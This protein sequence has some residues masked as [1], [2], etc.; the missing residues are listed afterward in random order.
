MFYEPF[1]EPVGRPVPRLEPLSRRRPNLRSRA[2]PCTPV[3]SSETI[4]TKTAMQKIA[5]IIQTMTME[6]SYPMIPGLTPAALERVTRP[7]SEG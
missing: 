2:S 5:T 4:P 6:P 7:H 3:P 1:Y